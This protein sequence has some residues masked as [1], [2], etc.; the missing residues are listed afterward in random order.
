MTRTRMIA[1]EIVAQIAL[2]A[3][4][5]ICASI[6]LAGAA[7]LLS[8]SDEEGFPNTFTQAWSAGTPVVSL[9]VDPDHIIE[10]FGLG[11]VSGNADRAVVDINA[12]MDSPQSRGEIS[13]RA[14]RFVAENYSASAVVQLFHRALDGVRK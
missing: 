10:R 9:T 12:L 4:I 6:V 1:A 8:T 13:D 2:A 7:L 14:R 3:A 5:G 11:T